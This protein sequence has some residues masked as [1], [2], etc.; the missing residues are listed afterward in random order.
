M[1]SV[2]NGRKRMS[3]LVKSIRNAGADPRAIGLSRQSCGSIIHGRKLQ[4]AIASE[5]RHP[6]LSDLALSKGGIGNSRDQGPTLIAV[7]SEI[8]VTSNVAPRHS[9]PSGQLC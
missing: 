9:A 1:R 6:W 5:P 4:R 7:P 3:R 8:A 2:L